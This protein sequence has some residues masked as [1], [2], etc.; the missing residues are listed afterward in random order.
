MENTENRY[1]T[2]DMYASLLELFLNPNDPREL[3][4]RPYIQGEFVFA[5]DSYSLIAFKKKLTDITK[6]GKSTKYPDALSV[7]PEGA[8]TDVSIK[9]P[10]LRLAL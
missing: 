1:S 5:T 7:I 10:E 4:K 6:F 3:L 9:L 2:S 8:N